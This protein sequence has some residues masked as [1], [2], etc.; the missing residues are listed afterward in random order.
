MAEGKNL[1]QSVLI[2]SLS[3]WQQK[4]KK[5]VEKRKTQTFS[6]SMIRLASFRLPFSVNAWTKVIRKLSERP[7][8]HKSKK[9]FWE[10]RLAQFSAVLLFDFWRFLMAFWLNRND[11]NCRHYFEITHLCH[12]EIGEALHKY[13]RVWG[14]KLRARLKFTMFLAEEK[15]FK[16][17]WKVKCNF[18]ISFSSAI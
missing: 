13:F 15:L 7:S 3:F 4:S 6:Q 8:A 16:A 10:R 14:K 2:F 18:F 9:L 11:F 1:R 17:L 12:V 5:K